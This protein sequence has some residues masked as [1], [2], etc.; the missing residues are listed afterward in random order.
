M[1]DLAFENY[2][3]DEILKM[4][5]GHRTVAFEYEL[6]NNEEK[7]ITMLE[8]AE[9]SI[10]FNSTAEIMGTASLTFREIKDKHSYTDMRVRPW[11]KLLLPNRNWARF[12]LG[13]YILTTPTRK[14][15]SG[16]AYV[17]V[18]CYDKTIILQEDKL[19]DRLFIQAGANYVNEIRKVLIS[20]GIEKSIITGSELTLP[21]DQEYEI[22]SSKLEVINSLLKAINYTPIHFDRNGNATAEPYVEPDQRA[23]EYGYSTD[24]NSLILAGGNQQN[25]LYNIPNVI[26][27][28]VDSPDQEAL[29]AEYINNDDSSPLSIGRRG[30]RI[31]DVEPVDDIAD[32]DTLNAY[33]RRVA[34]EKTQIN[35]SVVLP[36]ALMPH[37]EYRNCIFVRND[38]LGVTSKYIEYAWSMTLSAGEM[39]SHTLKKVIRL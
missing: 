24:D 15:D 10:A 34:F 7:V 12:P 14:D 13:I 2:S 1:Y 39:M 25:D 21:A 11:F 8:R 6:M 19:T 38:R 37:H 27:R 18:E 30:R 9:C 16:S 32:Q 26:I 22:G 20:S 29:R 5:S 35:D 4:L 36:T 31:V 28:Y 3:H 17:D 23:A 33:V